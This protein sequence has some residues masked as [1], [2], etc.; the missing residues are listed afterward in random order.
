MGD[1]SFVTEVKLSPVRIVLG[2]KT[3][4]LFPE[5]K[6]SSLRIVL[7]WEAK[8]LLRKLSILLLE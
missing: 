3:K 7:G 4:V 2:W 8:V 6:H 5:V 1:Q